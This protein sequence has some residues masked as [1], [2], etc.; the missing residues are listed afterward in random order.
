M[1]CPLTILY[2]S[3]I[4]F[5]TDSM[6]LSYSLEN[7]IQLTRAFWNYLVINFVEILIVLR[8]LDSPFLQVF[9]K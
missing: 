5:Q 2:L 9:K 4:L 1:L 7:T 8:N 6:S 3:Y